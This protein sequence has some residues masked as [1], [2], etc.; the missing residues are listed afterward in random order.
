M[1][2]MMGAAALG[3][4]NKKLTTALGRAFISLA[5]AP[6]TAIILVGTAAKAYRP[7]NHS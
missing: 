6:A 4:A 7:V 5:I 1:A 3:E 2:E